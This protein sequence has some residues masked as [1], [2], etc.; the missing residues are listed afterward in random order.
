MAN[1]NFSDIIPSIYEGLNV[2]SRE[3]VGFIPSILKNTGAER[4][5]KGETIRIP[6]ATAGDLE[7]ISEAMATPNTGD[8]T[9]GYVDMSIDN[10]YVVP[11]H[12]TGEEEL[13][14]SNSGQYNKVLADQFADCFRKLSNKIEK[15]CAL[16][17]IAG[18]SRATGTAGTTP[19]G[20]AGDL[21]DIANLAQILD[22]NGAPI[23]GRNLVLSSPAMASMRGKQSLLLKTN[24]A[25]SDEF[26]RTGYTAPI[27]GFSIWSSA[28]IA[29][30]T[31]G[32]G[33]SYVTNLAASLAAGAT[34]IAVDTGSGTVL[35]G[36]VVTFADDTN[37]YVVG[38]GI[39][40]AGSLSINNPG[41]LQALADGKA[42]TV[43]NDYTPSVAFTKNAIALVARPPKAPSVG[44]NAI[45]A[46]L[47][48]DPISGL[49][50]EVRVYG[51]YR[52]VRFE[53]GLAWGVKCIKPEHCALLLG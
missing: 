53:V 33:A 19:F 31:K 29:K 38:K 48:T 18:A 20:T 9:M 47:V 37:K 35:A 15:D 39:T 11:F 24:E 27:E 49:T 17:A 10:A 41:L 36:D 30:H 32:T 52:Q 51:G 21:S 6:L 5:A 50:F 1:L 12:W 14:V 16:A 23:S 2:V 8:V 3:Q 42:M 22:D 4:A 25:G 13:G 40:A 46:T 26:L 28:G 45:D 44:D 34:S 7:S 43:G